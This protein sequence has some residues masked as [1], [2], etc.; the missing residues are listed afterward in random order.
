MKYIYNWEISIVLLYFVF[1]NFY[2]F[3]DVSDSRTARRKWSH[4]HDTISVLMFIVALSD[5]DKCEDDEVSI[6]ILILFSK[7]A[8]NI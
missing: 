7:K 5:Y 8:G 2:R 3:I 1:F 4:L 6:F